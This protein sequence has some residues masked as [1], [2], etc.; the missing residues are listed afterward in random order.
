MPPHSMLELSYFFSNIMLHSIVVQEYQKK[1]FDSI[2][3]QF[4]LNLH[5]HKATYNPVLFVVV[6]RALN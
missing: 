3:I 1:A 2:F 6:C 5:L 4:N